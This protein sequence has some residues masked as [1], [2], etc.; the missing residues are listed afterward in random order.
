MSKGGG[1]VNFPNPW[2]I[3]LGGDGSTVHIDSGL[4]DI[5]IT[6]IAPITTNS[7]IAI[8]QPIVTNATSKSD[9]DANVDLKI[10][11]LDIKV[12]PL[13]LKIEPLKLDA[14]TRSEIDLKPVVLDSCTTVKLAPLPPICVEAPYSTHF[15][16]TYM[17]MEVW[18]INISG[19][20]ETFLHSPPKPQ[21]F[22]VPKPETRNSDDDSTRK[23]DQGRPAGGLR[24]RVK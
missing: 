21:S 14:A 18:G 10:E 22:H 6:Q 11:P 1:G 12:E 16:I 7:N 8:T 23:P 4:D 17:G 3:Q 9:S 13:D 19:R 24:V 5:A 2:D 15:G 20:N